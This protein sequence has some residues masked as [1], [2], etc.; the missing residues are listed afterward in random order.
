MSGN[1]SSAQL[2][3]GTYLIWTG[4]HESLLTPYHSRDDDRSFVVTRDTLPF[5]WDVLLDK[6]KRLYTIKVH[7]QQSYIV[8]EGNDFILEDTPQFFDIKPANGGVAYEIYTTDNRL[9]Q[10]NGDK[11]SELP[12]KVTSIAKTNAFSSPLRLWTFDEL[13]DDIPQQSGYSIYSKNSDYFNYSHKKKKLLLPRFGLK[14]D[15]PDRWQKLM[16]QIRLLNAEAKGSVIYKLIFLGRHGFAYNN[17]QSSSKKQVSDDNGDLKWDA[18]LTQDGLMQVTDTHDMW[19]TESSLPNGGIGVPQISY[20]SP[21]SRAMCTHSITFSQQLE[22]ATIRTVV[23]ENCREVIYT[24]ESEKRRTASYISLVFP[25]FGLE[26]NFVQGTDPYWNKDDGETL[27]AADDRAQKVVDRIFKSESKEKIFVSITAHH[28]INGAIISALG[29]DPTLYPRYNGGIVPLICQYIPPPGPLD[30]GFYTI[31]FVPDPSLFADAVGVDVPVVALDNNIHTPTTWFVK[32]VDA[33]KQL[34]IIQYFYRQTHG[35]PKP[36]LYWTTRYH[37]REKYVP[38]LL[39]YDQRAWRLVPSKDFGVYYIEGMSQS[40]S[41][42]S[43]GLVTVESNSN[44]KGKP[45]VLQNVNN[46]GPGAPSW[47][48]IPVKFPWN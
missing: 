32:C 35:M 37:E 19:M 12:N 43:A 44:A 28:E 42:S 17:I 46:I 2:P 21:L 22:A 24:S 16:R 27:T 45:L 48:F 40:N 7:N 38:V 13:D 11:K 34:Y 18:A 23:V 8:S 4:D 20:C 47:R 15:S 3:S 25:H 6:T 10:Y 36:K 14:D 33:E 29:G 39:S 1:K 9:V 41:A 30:D 5:Q 31:E 26:S